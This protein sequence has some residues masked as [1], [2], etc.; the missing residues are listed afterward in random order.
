MGKVVEL[1]TSYNH[2]DAIKTARMAAI[3]LSI[4]VPMA[5]CSRNQY[6]VVERTNVYRDKQGLRGRRRSWRARGRW[7][8][9]DLGLASCRPAGWM[10][11]CQPL[12]LFL[13][14]GSDLSLAYARSL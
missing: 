3:V 5:A 2:S 14:V 13:G 12:Q 11:E 7:A 8:A 9:C 1:L 4:L 6:R 10:G